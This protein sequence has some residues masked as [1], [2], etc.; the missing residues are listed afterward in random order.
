MKIRSLLIMS[1]ILVLSSCTRQFQELSM[2]SENT[3]K[4]TTEHKPEVKTTLTGD[5]ISGYR[6]L[7]ADNDTIFV[8]NPSFA[9]EPASFSGIK[10]YPIHSGWN[11]TMAEFAPAE[12]SFQAAEGALVAAFSNLV[13]KDDNTLGWTL[14]Q[15]RRPEQNSEVNN[16]MAA[17]AKASADSKLPYFEFKNLGGV[18]RLAVTGD[19]TIS[20]IVF[21]SD[22]NI[23]GSLDFELTEEGFAT[24]LTEGEK[25]YSVTLALTEPVMLNTE[26][27]TFF[28]INLPSTG[29]E[30][31]T[32][33]RLDFCG[34]DGTII[35][36][37]T[38]SRELTI[39][40]SR[41][42]TASLLIHKRWYRILRD[43]ELTTQEVLDRL[44]QEL[45][46]VTEYTKLVNVF[47]IV[48]K[49]RVIDFEYLSK[50][51]TG[52]LC[53]HSASLMIPYTRLLGNYYF[54]SKNILIGNRYT[55]MDDSK[56]PSRDLNICALYALM[57]H[58][59][60]SADLIGSGSSVQKPVNYICKHYAGINTV[61]AALVAQQM[62]MSGELG[63]ETESPF[64]V[65]N[66][67]YSQGG[68]DALA[69]HK[70]MVSDAPEYVRKMVP[71]RRS[72][73]GGGPYNPRVTIESILN[74][75][76]YNYSAMIAGSLISL[77]R[78]H[79]RDFGGN[80]TL[81][82]MFSDEAVD[83]G[84]ISMI[85]SKEV[86]QHKVNRYF[87]GLLGNKVENYFSDE[88][89]DPQN[90]LH[91]TIMEAAELEN[92]CEGEWCSN[93]GSLWFFHAE[94]DDLVPVDVLDYT[95]EKINA[96][97]VFRSDYQKEGSTHTA[98]YLNYMLTILT[99]GFFAE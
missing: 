90:D 43:R 81:E 85:E 9:A 2:P 59:V 39:D 26:K 55:Q 50:D 89:L 27:P 61:D 66:E 10:A 7:W 56:V 29:A 25:A 52:G 99:E 97:K 96:E 3:L 37:R 95:L 45:P 77:Y 42:T 87:N 11:T 19:A 83:A 58:I 13:R 35:E 64:P 65:Y 80:Y 72:L 57:N 86:E 71:L 75:D 21:T 14:V 92:L 74:M 53:T 1:A 84:L 68:Y 34:T 16:P 94:Y 51:E 82:E 78:Y 36:T 23:G 47:I 63:I 60:V 22:R 18:L 70:Y 91:K 46:A 6:T 31:Y 40:R 49:L 76:T 54:R 69:V 30:G 41:V 88:L 12:D 38:L 98:S 79:H 48:D 33:V 17:F 73:C 67:G 93:P 62:L 44:A 5:D 32:G 4:A 28:N 15:V 8:G 24:S 20:S